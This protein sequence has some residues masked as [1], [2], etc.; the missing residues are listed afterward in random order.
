MELL[1]REVRCSWSWVCTQ[2]NGLYKWQIFQ[3]VLSTLDSKNLKKL[4][5]KNK[6]WSK[7]RRDLAD[8]EEKLQ[9]NR[10]KNQ[11]RRLTRKGK[12]LYEK[13]IAS[14]VKSNPKAFWQY[15]Q[16]KL[17]TR[18]QIPDI[19]KPGTENNPTYSKNDLEKPKYLAAISAVYLPVSQTRMKCHSL[20]KWTL[21]K[22]LIT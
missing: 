5:R 20:E 13:N 4:K 3:K 22:N 9:Y 18:S 21:Q 2:K 11:I 7:I 16:S 10:L 14:N 15:T 12:K 8:E 17:K 6:L 19:I 1:Q